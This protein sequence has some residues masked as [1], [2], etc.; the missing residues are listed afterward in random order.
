MPI[1]V[2]CPSCLT[3]FSVSEKFAGKSGPCPKCKAIIKIPELSE[4]VVVHAPVDSAPK[5]SKGKSVLKP[6]RREETK[7]SM[8]VIVGSALAALVAVGV[9][10][11]YR[12]NPTPP[13]AAVLAA[14][15]IL[16]AAP[17]VYAGYWF[18]RDDEL[19]GFTGRELLV[20]CTICAVVFALGWAVYAWVPGFVADQQSLSE[21]SALM[22]ALMI[23]VMVALGATAAV[24]TLEL[25]IGQGLLL[26]LMYLIITFALTWLSG[27][28][29]SEILPGKLSR[30]QQAPINRPVQD[31]PATPDAPTVE[32]PP[33]Q[34]PNLL[35]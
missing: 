30:Q 11:G 25:E 2:T 14:A 28:P 20:R 13:P 3:R 18:L 19:Q 5:D 15:S 1:P 34:V 33:V 23:G 32:P 6:I 21:T 7:L 4:Q 8:P 31:A 35:Q 12:L 16:L 9:A 27:T 17:L 10:F 22:M 26:H 29:L 24:L